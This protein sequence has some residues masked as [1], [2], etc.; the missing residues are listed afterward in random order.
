MDDRWFESRQR[1][2]I[3]LFTTASRLDLGPTQPPIQWVLGTLSLGAKRPG[4]EADPSPPSSA[5]VKNAWS[6]TSSPPIHLHSVVQVK[7][8]Q[9]Q[10]Y[11]LTLYP[12]FNR[13]LISS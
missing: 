3:F 11:F 12:E 1:L 9:G 4:R 6:Y 13:L 8:A 2:G 5:E 7:N 10:L